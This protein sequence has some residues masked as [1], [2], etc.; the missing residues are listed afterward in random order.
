MFQTN[1]MLITLLLLM[2]MLAG[3]IGDSEEFDTSELDEQISDLQESLDEQNNTTAQKDAQIQSLLALLED[4]NNTTAQKDAQIQSLL[5]LLEDANNTIGDLELQLNETNNLISLCDALAE[6]QIYYCHDV[7]PLL[8]MSV[9]PSGT[10]KVGENV[11]FDATGS[12]DP[13]EDPLYF[14]W[15]FGDGDIASGMSAYHVYTSQ[16]T[17]KAKLCVISTDF[18]I[19][20]ERDVIV[21]PAD[22]VLPTVSIIHYKDNDCTGEE[23]PAG[24]YI[25]AWICEEE[26]ETSDDT[27]DATTTIQLDGSDSSAGDANSYLTEFEWDLDTYIDSDG[28]G[29]TDNDVD[30]T[31]ENAE[32]TNVWP[33]EY[34][35]R[36]TV[37]DNQGFTD[38]RNMDVFVNYRGAWAEFTIDSNGTS[39]PGTVTFEYPVVYQKQHSSQTHS[40]RYVTIE[41]VYPQED[42]DWAVGSGQNRLDLYAYNGSQSDSDTEEM[43]NTTH[44]TDEDM[45]CD[46]EDRCTEL[47]LRTTQFRNFN[48]GDFTMLWTVDLV[49]EK[50]T[51]ATVKSFAITLEYK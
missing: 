4:A 47:T 1:S 20:E 10:V 18:E 34:E 17:F 49:N 42:D 35:I 37:T 28:D 43:I 36:L 31:G 21:A 33:G 29:V 3:C 5:A 2:S 22:A 7:P 25:L 16:G 26:M 46:D 12:S 11:H 39:G 15:V 14:I 32:W 38:T 23:P 44:L 45:N 40:I 41:A 8:S 30:Q 6:N 48:N 19:C 24:T 13:N 51:D 27:I 9:S 50:F